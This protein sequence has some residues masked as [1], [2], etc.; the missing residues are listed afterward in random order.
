MSCCVFLI[1]K[2]LCYSTNSAIIPKC[3]HNKV[4]ES[5]PVAYFTKRQAQKFRVRDEIRFSYMKFMY[6]FVG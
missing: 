2:V 3:V 6:V 1:I 4:F 5:S